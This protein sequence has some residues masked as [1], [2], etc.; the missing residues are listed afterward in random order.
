[1]TKIINLF[2]GPG[3]GKSTMAAALFANLKMKGI[4]CELVHE[5]AKI[6]V[7]EKRNE[8]LKCQPYI[9]GKQLFMLER[10]IEQVEYI[11][12]DSPILLSPIYDRSKNQ[13]FKEFVVDYFKKMDNINIFL[14]RNSNRLYNPKGRNQTEEESKQIDIQIKNFLLE[15]NIHFRPIKVEQDLAIT[16]NKIFTYLI[17][18]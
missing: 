5:I 18:Y 1:M 8:A 4:N 13:L 17:P 12:T 3:A 10:L 15:N 7:W 9:F 2:A 14:E 16:V 6:L 11:I